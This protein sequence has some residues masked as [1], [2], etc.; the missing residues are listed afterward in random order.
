MELF[1]VK[2]ILMLFKKFFSQSKDREDKQK[3][4]VGKFFAK[5]K[6]TRE[7]TKAAKAKFESMSSETAMSSSSQMQQ[8]MSSSSQVD[9]SKTTSVSSKTSVSK[10]ESKSASQIE[11]AKQSGQ[12]RKQEALKR[13][14]LKKITEMCQLFVYLLVNLYFFFFT[15]NFSGEKN[16]SLRSQ[17][18]NSQ[19]MSKVLRNYIDNVK[20]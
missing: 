6:Q 1:F 3:A 18:L 2:C 4:I 19:A 9:F 11:V 10:F 20:K 13:S 12:E 16:L 17:K 14:V 15:I 8:S 5:E 7:S